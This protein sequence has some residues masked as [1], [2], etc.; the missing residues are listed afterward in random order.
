MQKKKKILFLI[1]CILSSCI[2]QAQLAIAPEIGI[3]SCS[4]KVIPPTPYTLISSGSIA[5]GKIGG[6]ADIGLSEHLYF[7][8]GLFFT[9]KG[10]TKSLGYSINDSVQTID[11]TFKLHYLE[12]PLYV[13][14]KTGTQG[15]GR[16]FFGLGA[17]VDYVVGG[18]NI[19]HNYGSA[20]KQAS[21]DT[22]TNSMIQ[23]GRDVS[24]IDVGIN[25][26]AGYEFRWGLFLRA[27]YYYGFTDISN[28]LD[29]SDKNINYGFSAGYFL[30]KSRHTNLANELIA[31]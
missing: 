17:S 12:I 3:S 16:V 20:P 26:M 1:G 5:G 25:F 27:Y 8:S 10:N 2:A 15:M 13:L 4:M 29:E 23:A 31:E 11:Q 30:S 28:F 22:S 21:F 19:M 14:F 18:R 9:I 6:L 24:D 7:Q